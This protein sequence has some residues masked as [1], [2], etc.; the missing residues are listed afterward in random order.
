MEPL[1]DY[2]WYY[3][4][5][6]GPLL[7]IWREPVWVYLPVAIALEECEMIQ[8]GEICN[9][10]KGTLFDNDI[11]IK[12]HCMFTKNVLIEHCCLCYQ[13]VYITKINMLRY[14]CLHDNWGQAMTDRDIVIKKWSLC[15]VWIEVIHVLFCSSDSASEKC[16]DVAI[17]FV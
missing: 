7:L 6:S 1:V 9:S 8:V 13:L 2:C 3:C 11:H 10:L 5:S 16:T 15:R 4:I 14:I 17:Y 12:H